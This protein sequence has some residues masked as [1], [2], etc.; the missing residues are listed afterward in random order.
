MA[1]LELG[2][3][4]TASMGSFATHGGLPPNSLF[5]VL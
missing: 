3:D 2:A 1:L 4:P 5:A